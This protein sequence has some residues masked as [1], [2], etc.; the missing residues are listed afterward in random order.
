MVDSR[1]CG[2]N[3]YLIPGFQCRWVVGVYLA[4]GLVEPGPCHMFNQFIYFDYHRFWP[5]RSS[6][7][8]C[9]SET[10]DPGENLGELVLRDIRCLESTWHLHHPV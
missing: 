7:S 8:Q 1:I 6:L 9:V 2:P 10:L 4:D 3:R 5:G